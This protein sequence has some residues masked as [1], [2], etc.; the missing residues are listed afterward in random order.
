MGAENLLVL[1]TTISPKI[2]SGVQKVFNTVHIYVL[3]K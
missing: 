1:F 2:E 3:N